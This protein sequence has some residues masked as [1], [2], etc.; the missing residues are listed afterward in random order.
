MKKLTVFCAVLLAATVATA[1]RPSD[2]ALL[3]P[4]TAPE[5]NYAPVP[6]A[7][8]LPE[9]MK[10]GA[11]AAVAF[12]ARGHLYVLTRGEQAFFE[13]DET[14]AFVRAFGDKMFTRSHGLRI[15][16]DGN[17]W[18]TD[19]GAHTV[20]K[21]NPKGEVLLTL[22]T[23]GEAGEWN[24]AAGSRKLN[25]PND[26]AIAANGDVFVAQ[27][28]TPG[29][30]GDARVLKFDRDGRFIKSWGGKGKEPGQFDV[31]HGIAIDGKGLLWVMD[32]E[33]QRIE[34]FDADGTFVREQK[35]K[36]LP[37]SVAFARD[38]AFMV[39]GFAGQLLRLDLAG[40]V[41]AATGKPGTALGEFGE[42]HF[43]AISPRG[44]LYVADSVNG[45]LTKYVRRQAR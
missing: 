43:L 24:E 2:P 1:Q 6:N 14:G 8:T 11:S 19:V 29:A 35:Y 23:K 15:D 20:L 5:L 41:L 16:R 31:A 3:V 42:A 40:Q 25:Q 45:A 18:A 37:C 9:G 21:L 39:N 44:D 27:G 12:D 28:H 10:M 38:E 36:G 30:R 17:L 22:G 13:F 4:E 26:V 34:V 7:V 32:R 33:N